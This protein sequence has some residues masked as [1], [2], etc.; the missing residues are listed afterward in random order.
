MTVTVSRKQLTPCPALV[1]RRQTSAADIAKTLSEILPRVFQHAVKQG[2][3]FAGPPFTRYVEMGIGLL[4]VEAGMS[5]AAPSTDEGD[6]LSVEL[7]GGPVA[8]AIHMGPYDQLPRTHAEV[9]R[10]IAET[11]ARRAG[12]PWEVYITDPGDVPDP[13][14]WQT[15][16]IYPL[17]S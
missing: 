16:V 11:G 2:I 8:S 5:I 7:P 14:D 17:S 13:K 9:E 4:T 12:A 6:I 15:E 1:I 10:W 3:A